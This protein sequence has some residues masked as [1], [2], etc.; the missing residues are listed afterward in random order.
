MLILLDQGA[1]VGIRKSL[2]NHT[3]KTAYEMGWST[4]LNGDLLRVAEDAGFQLLLTTDKNLVHQ[5]NLR[6][7]K[8]G[9]LVLG[10]ARWKA[11]QP[12]L[13]SIAEKISETRPGTYTVVDIPVR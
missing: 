5:Q 12:F 2:R 13:D 8:I 1:P 11:I 7:R 10:Q 9:V 4:F 3:V 6:N